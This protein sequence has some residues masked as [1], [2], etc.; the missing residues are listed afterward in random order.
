MTGFKVIVLANMPYNNGFKNYSQCYLAFDYD[1]KCVA[2]YY[3]ENSDTRS[4]YKYKVTERAVTSK[5]GTGA[6]LK[7]L[8]W[9]RYGLDNYY[10]LDRVF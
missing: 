5:S 8:K 4:N 1:D 3:E 9:R 6:I 7:F 2:E 10:L